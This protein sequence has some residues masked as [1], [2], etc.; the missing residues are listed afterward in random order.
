M[1]LLN[2]EWYRNNSEILQCQHCLLSVRVL[3]VT[4]L[5]FSN[6]WVRS[7]LKKKKREKVKYEKKAC[8]MVC[9]LWGSAGRTPRHWC[10]FAVL[11][12]SS[13][14]VCGHSHRF[15]AGFWL[16]LI[17]E[18]RS[19]HGHAMTTS[20]GLINCVLTVGEFAQP[21]GYPSRAQGQILMP[22]WN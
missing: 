13:P 21:K 7:E 12:H 18:L 5:G 15:W 10:G 2:S 9:E 8:V 14:V 22:W 19:S 16:W 17:D 6:A 20:F 4:S 1:F 11:R 3:S